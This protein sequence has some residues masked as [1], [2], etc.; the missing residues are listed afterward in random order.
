[1]FVHVEGVAPQVSTPS[2]CTF[3]LLLGFKARFAYLQECQ[4][5]FKFNFSCRAWLKLERASRAKTLRRGA[6]FRIDESVC[7]D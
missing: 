2:S 7:R 3:L 4:Q 5:Y 1:M 6:L